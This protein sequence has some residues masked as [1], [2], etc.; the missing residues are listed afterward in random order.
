MFFFV[1]AMLCTSC[2]AGVAPR[3]VPNMG[4]DVAPPLFGLVHAQ[5]HQVIQ[6][7]VA[8]V[9]RR[10]DP[11]N[12]QNGKYVHSVATIGKPFAVSVRDRTGALKRRFFTYERV[13]AGVRVAV[14]LGSKIL[15]SSA[16]TQQT[17][18]IKP[19]KKL[20]HPA[21]PASALP[22]LTTPGSDSGNI[23]N[24]NPAGVCV[25]VCVCEVSVW[26][27]FHLF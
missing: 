11:R 24:S 1:F 18:I 16:P 12:F 13:T 6:G 20:L 25:C 8:G 9:S 22:S 14:E 3:V 21:K 19:K 27:L 23:V 4:R 26:N 15:I 17:K 2:F 10:N 7:Q 5:P